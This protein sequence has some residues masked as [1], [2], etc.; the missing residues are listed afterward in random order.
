M[1][2]ECLDQVPAAVNLDI[3]SLAFLQPCDLSCNM[4]GDNYRIISSGICQGF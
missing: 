3:R 1:F 2:Q 4:P